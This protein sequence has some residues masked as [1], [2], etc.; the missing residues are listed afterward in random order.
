MYENSVLLSSK[1]YKNIISSN[2]LNKEI[3]LKTQL[4]GMPE[5]LDSTSNIKG[6]LGIRN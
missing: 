3:G 4:N 6:R 1:K 5:A 2:S